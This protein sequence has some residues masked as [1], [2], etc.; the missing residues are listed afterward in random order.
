M[1]DLIGFKVFPAVNQ[2]PPDTFCRQID[3]LILQGPSP[4]IEVGIGPIGVKRNNL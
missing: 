3:V 1:A 4:G 2:Q